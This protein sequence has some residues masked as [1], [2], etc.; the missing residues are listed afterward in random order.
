MFHHQC[1]FLLWNIFSGKITQKP[2]TTQL[3]DINFENKN[4]EA[5]RCSKTIGRKPNQ[6]N[7]IKIIGL[8]PTKSQVAAN[9]T[10]PKKI[11]RVNNMNKTITVAAK[12]VTILVVLELIL[13]FYLSSATIA[14][15][16]KKSFLKK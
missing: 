13:S 14:Q 16:L 8:C 1:Q 11:S 9:T 6:G 2:S 3:C 15:P 5:R 4:V 12:A 7:Q 10:V